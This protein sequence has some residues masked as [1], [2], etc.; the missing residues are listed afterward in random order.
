MS[1][2]MSRWGEPARK[3]GATEVMAAGMKS[4]K[5]VD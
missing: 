1:R 5:A 2:R 4:I 3:H